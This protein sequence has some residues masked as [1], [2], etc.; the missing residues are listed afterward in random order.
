[1]RAYK[2]IVF[3]AI[4][5]LLVMMYSVLCDIIINVE[6]PFYQSLITPTINHSTFFLLIMFF[7]NC[8]MSFVLGETLLDKNYFDTISMW[9]MLFLTRIF[10]LISFFVLNNLYLSNSFA[11]IATCICI[12]MLFVYIKKT[13]YRGIAMLPITIWFIYLFLYNYSIV[14]MN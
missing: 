7:I 12:I 9:V 3:L 1:M 6:S 4:G 13:R 11:I 2:R 10:S 14:K 5:L 8:L